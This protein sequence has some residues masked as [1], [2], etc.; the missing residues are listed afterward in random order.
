M[1]ESVPGMP[2]DSKYLSNVY[3]DTGVEFCGFRALGVH[4]HGEF[5]IARF[6]LPYYA[7]NP[8]TKLTKDPRTKG[9]AGIATVL[10]HN[11]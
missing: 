8:T 5:W 9:K 10:N 6:P 11:V 7:S 4:L 2:K 3:R 1:R